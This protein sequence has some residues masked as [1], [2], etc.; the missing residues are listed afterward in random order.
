MSGKK[1]LK[2]ALSVLVLGTFVGVAV[3][4]IESRFLNSGGVLTGDVV[5]EESFAT[6]YAALGQEGLETWAIGKDQ[7]AAKWV[8]APAPAAGG[9]GPTFNESSCLEC[10]PKNSRAKPMMDGQDISKGTVLRLSVP[11]GFDAKVFVPHP[12]YGEQLQNRSSQPHTPVE[13]QA[14][15]MFNTVDFQYPDGS[16][17]TL[18]NPVFEFTQM[19]FGPLGDDVNVSPRIAPQVIGLGLLE[20]VP[21]ESILA[22]AQ[23]QK[24]LGLSGEA[25]YVIDRETGIKKLGRFGWKAS[26]PTVKHQ[27]AHAFHSDIGV[28]NPLFPEQNCPVVQVD[29]TE[30]EDAIGQNS[31]ALTDR[32]NNI[33]WYLQTLNVPQRRIDDP[34]KVSVGERLFTDTGC[35]GCHVDTMKTGDNAPHEEL[36]NVTFHPYT[37]LLRHDMGAGLSEIRMDGL[38]GSSEWRTP[39]LWG[40]GLINSLSGELGLLHDGRAGTIEEAILWHGGEAAPS[41]MRFA[42]LS[43]KQ[44]DAVIAFINSL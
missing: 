2:L 1:G 6:P 35:A 12:I 17:V 30:P 36:R 38:P 28:T 5:G 24:K 23:E 9:L 29:C 40:I 10:H 27:V 3:S 18:K 44:R 42:Y 41:R 22:L 26:D 37:D 43:Q 19:S 8:P 25:S 39:P 15:N 20:W 4:A 34:D 13:G 16:K 32:L 14:I 21:E 11:S 31:E 33:T 7:F